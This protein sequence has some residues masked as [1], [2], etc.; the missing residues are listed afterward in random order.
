MF[1]YKGNHSSEIIN[2][3]INEDNESCKKFDC[4]IFLAVILSIQYFKTQFSIFKVIV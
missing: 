1:F 4:E 3:K 2:L